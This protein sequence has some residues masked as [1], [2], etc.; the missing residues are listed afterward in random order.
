MKNMLI[1]GRFQPFHSGH[2]EIIKKYYKK[3]YFIKIVIGSTQKAHQRKNPFTK[4]ERIEM[5]KKTLEEHK[6][7][8]Y[9]LTVV[10]DS[11]CDKEWI[12]EV[13]KKTGKIDVVFTGNLWVKRLFKKE[14]I[15][16]HEYNEK[17]ERIKG[18]KAE[19]IRKKLTTTKTK[20]GLP[21]AVYKQ[22]KIIRAF[23]RLKDMHDPNKKVHYLLSTNKKTISAAES[24][25]GGEISRA[26]VSYSG[27]SKFFKGSL[28]AYSLEA[29]QKLLRINKKTIKKYGVVSKE[30]A[31]EMSETARKIFKT[32]Y[33]ISTTGYADPLDEY[34][35][36]VWI[37]VST[38]KEGTQRRIEIKEK[39][40]NKIIQR[41][42]KQAIKELYKLLTKDI[43]RK[44]VD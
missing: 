6:I 41:A 13:K 2:L 27:S 34:A 31:K 9:S 17:L 19:D 12:E 30:V 4:E 25:T 16:I 37:S 5:I 10:P 20:K 29:K 21:N 42:T 15:E 43:L 11:P 39:D 22:L 44:G 32:D 1:I 36:L 38:K 3:N 26:L 35:G 33:A 23:D 18:I 40:R 8:K 14:N 7:K 24:C 28:I